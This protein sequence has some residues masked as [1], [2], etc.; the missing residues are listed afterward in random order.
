MF[1]QKIKVIAVGADTEKAP[2]RSGLTPQPDQIIVLEVT[3]EQAE[4]IVFARQF[5]SVTLMLLPDPEDNAYTPF[6]ARG[7]LTRDV[8]DI[9]ERIIE[10]LEEVESRLGT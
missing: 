3:P 8:L 4:K 7:I 1:E 6:D 5:T 10:Q 9:L 2:L